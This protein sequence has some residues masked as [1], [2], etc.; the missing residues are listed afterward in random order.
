M[1]S[2]R[3]E[4]CAEPFAQLLARARSGH[5]AAMGQLMQIQREHLLEIARQR[6]PPALQ[7]RLAPSDAV[8]VALLAAHRHFEQFHGHS[9]GEFS[10]W[11]W[12]ILVNTIRDFLRATE[13]R[14]REHAGREVSLAALPPQ[15]RI[16]R[17]VR[18]REGGQS[19][20]DALIDQETRE[21]L[22]RCVEL[23]PD[24]YRQV[25]QMRFE[26]ARGFEEIGAALGISPQ[27]ALKMRRRAVE[28]VADM[29]RTY[30]V[31]EEGI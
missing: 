11:L 12:S 7:G 1:S 31:I 24:E 25:L 2:D 16:I 30:G 15:A 26:D 17:P 14:R 21:S 13:G 6:I 5:S 19:V 3:P 9:E 20:C 8:Q 10:E 27:A 18:C 28:A 29:M 22:R 4:P 23:L